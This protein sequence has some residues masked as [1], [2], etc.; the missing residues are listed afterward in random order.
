MYVCAEKK[1]GWSLTILKDAL[2][3]LVVDLM[4][5]MMLVYRMP[6]WGRISSQELGLKFMWNI[7]TVRP[8]NSK[9]IFDYFETGRDQIIMGVNAIAIN[10]PKRSSRLMMSEG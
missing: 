2:T 5:N 8:R 10:L 3:S 9:D 6:C 4:T 1:V 7:Q